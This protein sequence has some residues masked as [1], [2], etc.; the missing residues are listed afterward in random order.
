MHTL[1]HMHA[2]TPQLTMFVGL[3]ACLS[4]NKSPKKGKK[5][6][7]YKKSLEQNIKDKKDVSNASIWY[8]GT[9]KCI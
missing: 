2:H 6:R 8:K 1:A 3:L 9:A 4:L 5:A 7:V